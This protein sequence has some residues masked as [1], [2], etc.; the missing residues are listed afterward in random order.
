MPPVTFLTDP[1]FDV[2]AFPKIFCYDGQDAHLF[3][4]NFFFQ[5]VTFPQVFYGSKVPA[6][7]FKILVSN[8]K[9]LGHRYIDTSIMSH[10]IKLLRVM[11]STGYSII[12][13]PNPSP[14]V[15]LQ[16]ANQRPVI[17]LFEVR[18]GLAQSK[19]QINSVLLNLPESRASSCS[20]CPTNKHVCKANP[21][22]QTTI[23]PGISKSVSKG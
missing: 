19:F 12:C 23:K 22:I 8:Q 7:T 9:K 15:G 5:K 21:H 11:S 1:A 10:S 6:P 17:N 3:Y 20:E 4:P 13:P 18:S 14:E 2:N 16:L